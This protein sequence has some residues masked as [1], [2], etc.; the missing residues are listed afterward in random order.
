MPERSTRYFPCFLFFRTFYIRIS[1]QCFFAGD[2]GMRAQ[3]KSQRI[4]HRCQCLILWL[5]IGGLCLFLSISTHYS[6]PPQ[7]SGPAKKRNFVSFSSA[8]PGGARLIFSPGARAV[9]P[10]F[11][12]CKKIPVAD[13]TRR[14]EGRKEDRREL[15]G[16]ILGFGILFLK[17]EE[18]LPPLL[19]LLQTRLGHAWGRRIIT[20]KRKRKGKTMWVA[21]KS[22]ARSLLSQEEKN[23]TGEKNIQ[24]PRFATN[25]EILI[26]IKE[27]TPISRW[28]GGWTRAVASG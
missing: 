4:F 7:R 25:V 3:K 5:I 1:A 17:R 15:V 27:I 26:T 20:G 6:G 2:Q 11:H 24:V 23:L 12:T 14:W 13:G 16:G 10:P 8:K 18:K 28:W 21:S 22:D 9:I 19:L